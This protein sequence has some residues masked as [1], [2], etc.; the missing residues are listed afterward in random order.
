VGLG[1]G[2]NAF[3]NVLT[4]GGLLGAALWLSL[5]VGIFATIRRLW[6]VSS[7]WADLPMLAAVMCFFLVNS[8]TY[9]GLGDAANLSNVWCYVIVGWLSVLAGQVRMQPPLQRPNIHRSG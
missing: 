9:E 8:V 4:D 2:H 1:G 3:I 5:I 7:V 6:G